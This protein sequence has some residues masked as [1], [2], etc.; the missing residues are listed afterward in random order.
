[1]VTVADREVRLKAIG[2]ANSRSLLV[3]TLLVFLVMTV[4]GVELYS[5]VVV[6]N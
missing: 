1:M 4:I 2:I 3:A 5:H 6:S